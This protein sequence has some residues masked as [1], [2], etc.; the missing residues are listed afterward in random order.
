MKPKDFTSSFTYYQKDIRI[1]N[2]EQRYVKL[3]LTTK[4]VKTNVSRVLR[5]NPGTAQLFY[6]TYTAQWGLQNPKGF[7]VQLNNNHCFF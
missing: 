2:E 1:R 3:F 5:F 7:L 6:L 4:F